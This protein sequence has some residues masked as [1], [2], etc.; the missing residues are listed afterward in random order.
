MNLQNQNKPH[1]YLPDVIGKIIEEIPEEQDIIVYALKKIKTSALFG[2]PEL[3]AIWWK[4][5]YDLLQPILHTPI[6]GW[7]KKVRDIFLDKDGGDSDES[8][9]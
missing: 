9:E 4:K 5:T 8:T 1:R 3:Q 7:E 2:P 6:N